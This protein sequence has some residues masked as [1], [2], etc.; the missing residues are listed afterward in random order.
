MA[1]LASSR[2]KELVVPLAAGGCG[3]A[4]PEYPVS[5]RGRVLLKCR[6]GSMR[7]VSEST[8]PDGAVSTGVWGGVTSCRCPGKLE[9][10][11]VPSHAISKAPCSRVP[12]LQFFIH[13]HLITG[14]PEDL[15]EHGNPVRSACRRVAQ[16][17]GAAGC[18][19]SVWC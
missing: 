2:A 4:Y 8:G 10:L 14:N 18:I 13:A 16:G 5:I 3:R 1:M 9:I 6:S 12:A 11:R 17:G 19:S 15:I 7:C